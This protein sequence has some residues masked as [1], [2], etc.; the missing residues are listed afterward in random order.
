MVGSTITNA[1]SSKACRDTASNRPICSER[2]IAFKSYD[3]SPT[4]NQLGT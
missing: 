4:G 1:I 3:K 2:C